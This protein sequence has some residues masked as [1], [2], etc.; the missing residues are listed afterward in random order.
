[1]TRET[2][3]CCSIQCNL[4]FN[5]SKTLT[6]Y[7]YCMRTIL[8]RVSLILMLLLFVACFEQPVMFSDPSVMNGIL[9]GKITERC[10]FQCDTRTVTL[11]VKA[12]WKNTK[13][14]SIVASADI[15]NQ[16][17]LTV[18]GI[19]YVGDGE[20][21]VNPRT[22]ALR[23]ASTKLEFRDTTGTLVAVSD[24]WFMKTSYSSNS[25][26]NTFFGSFHL[27]A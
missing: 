5:S 9:K 17:G 24:N 4:S 23:P 14:Y 16:K 18:T 2:D 25:Q 15:G 12:I 3:F 21:L 19:G 27:I 10:S 6:C 11:E 7:N 8:T 20:Y 22:P 1:M 13:Q 26:P